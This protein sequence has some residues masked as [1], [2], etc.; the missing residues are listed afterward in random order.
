[1]SV[2][3]MPDGTNVSFPDDMPPEKIKELIANKFPHD[4]AS[5]L[6]NVADGLSSGMSWSEVAGNFASKYLMQ[7]VPEDQRKPES[8]SAA[9]A[10]GTTISNVPSS[11]GSFIKNTVEP[12]AHPI[13]TAE[14]LGS[15]GKGVMQK[16]GI[17]PGDDS[18]QY[19]DAVG[20]FLVN[21]YGSAD[22][23]QKTLQT[24]PVGVAA[25]LS[26]ILTGGGSLAARLPGVAGKVGE[27]A[28]AAGRAIDP[29][30]AVAATARGAGNVAAHAAGVTTGVGSDAI[31]VAAQSG[32]EGGEAGKAF[33]DSLTGTEDPNQVV[34][35]AKG[36]V[37]QMRQERGDLYRQDMAKIGAD[38]TIL[39]FDKIDDAVKRVAGVKTYKGQSLSAK[40][41]AIRQELTTA[42]EEW[43][44]LPAGD[45]HTPEG[46]DALKQKLGDIRD[47]TQ[48][49][50]ADRVVADGVYKAVYN[51]IT[52]QA[53]EY[54]KVMKGY[55]EAS[56]LIKEMEKTLSINPKA[57]VDTQLRKLQ[58][59]LRDNVNTNYGRRTELVEFLQRAGAPNL[60]Q[61]L[62][63]QMLSSA[64]PR[65]LGKVAAGTEG[66]TALAALAHGNPAIAAALVG[67]LGISSPLLVGGAA[68]ALG[69]ATR[70]PLRQLGRG[71]FQAGRL[72]Q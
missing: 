55:Q 11:A 66:I 23:V 30:N 31:K 35:E 56:D 2:V 39:D 16:L 37:S 65:G 6:K 71:A 45:F 42:V 44:N 4:V 29:L 18:K 17:V 32:V 38:N 15:L 69:S 51:T 5:H 46:L 21:R 12:L 3:Q 9:K 52:E 26:L 70:L 67:G 28:G 59:A 7:G 19:A 8:D 34:Q 20:Q 36:A 33:R 53:P 24:D 10:V 72:D 50:T 54:A 41:D 68:H 47:S 22:A 48:P 1:M 62:A 61:K 58:S 25:D 64:T 63:G 14:N 57:T 60:V 13:D 27:V 49:G 40:T 43:K